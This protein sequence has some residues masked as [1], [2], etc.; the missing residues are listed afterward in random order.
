VPLLLSLTRYI[1]CGPMAVDVMGGL[2][3]ATVLTCQFL[4][5]VYATWY[6]IPKDGS[7][8]MPNELTMEGEMP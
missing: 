3:V 2:V 6:R 1:F 4:P 8:K 5:A 7:L